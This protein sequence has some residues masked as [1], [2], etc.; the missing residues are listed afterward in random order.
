MHFSYSATLLSVV[1]SVGTQVQDRSQEFVS[2]TGAGQTTSAEVLLVVA[3]I[4]MWAI[5]FALVF[6]THRRQKAL[7][8]R[9]EEV[10]RE[11]E[12]HVEKASN[13]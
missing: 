13:G 5:V 1:D 11:L 12:R 4:L 2:V 6:L 10:E 8:V 7:G 9:L 3:Y